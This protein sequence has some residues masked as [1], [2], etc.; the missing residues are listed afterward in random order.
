MAKIGKLHYI[1]CAG[2]IIVAVVLSVI[3]KTAV[4]K[5]PDESAIRA[6]AE[7]YLSSKYDNE[8]LYGYEITSIDRDYGYN[9]EPDS[10]VV[11][12]YAKEHI[13][14]SYYELYYDYI[15]GDLIREYVER[16]Y[17]DDE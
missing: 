16:Q 3:L 14:F 11:R 13:G 17:D 15:G 1:V 7:E 2:I 4:F 8:F 10:W 6:N 12:A 5:M 9:D